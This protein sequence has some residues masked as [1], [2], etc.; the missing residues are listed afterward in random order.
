MG[1]QSFRLHRHCG[2]MDSNLPPDIRAGGLLGNMY[3]DVVAEGQ[4]KQY[5]AFKGKSLQSAS[6]NIRDLCLVRPKNLRHFRLSH[7]PATNDSGDLSRD[8]QFP[9]VVA[10][11]F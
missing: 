9:R 10:R 7:F 6:R 4:Q 5:Q 2:V 11:E 8:G 1:S 3:I